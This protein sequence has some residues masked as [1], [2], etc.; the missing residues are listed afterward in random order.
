MFTVFFHQTF[1]DTRSA[2]RQI[3]QLVSDNFA[4]EPPPKKPARPG[5]HGKPHHVVASSSATAS[6][7]GSARIPSDPIKTASTTSKPTTTTAE[8]EYKLT[9]PE[10]RN[11]VLRNIKGLV[12][13]FR[14][15]WSEAMSVRIFLCFWNL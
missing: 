14:I 2:F 10:F 1:N 6:A 15:E 13:L 11:I 3:S 7:S 5:Q 8:P 4:T 12:R 9:V